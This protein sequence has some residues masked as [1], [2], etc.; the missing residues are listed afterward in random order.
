MKVTIDPKAAAIYVKMR[1]GKVAR[2]KEF[3][4]EIFADIDS[5]GHLLGVEMLHPGTLGI[6]Q[7]ARKFH[8]PLLAKLAPDL[9][10]IYT[11]LASAH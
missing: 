6:K 2:T 8:R 11:K 1:D 3:A 9:D 10:R 5:A 7:V 4:P